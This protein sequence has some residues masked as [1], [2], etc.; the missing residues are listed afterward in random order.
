MHWKVECSHF[1]LAKEF[2]KAFQ[3]FVI[4]AGLKGSPVS[5]DDYQSTGQ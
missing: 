5:A 2:K 3:V 4:F 1:S